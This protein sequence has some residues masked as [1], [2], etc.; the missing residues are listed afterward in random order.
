MIKAFPKIFAIGT[1]YIKDI[2]KDEVEITEKVDGSQFCFADHSGTLYM[3][4][5]GKQQFAEAYDKMFKEAVSYALELY[6]NNTLPRD[7]VFYCEYLKTPKHN[8]LSY[9]LIPKN[10][11]M[12]FAIS[13]I[14]GSKFFDYSTIVQWANEL[15][16]DYAKKFP[17]TQ[18]NTINDLIDLLEHESYLG[19][20][21]IEGIV[22]KNY[23]R[24]FLLGG[25][26][27]PLMAGKFVSESFKEVNRSNFKKEHLTTGRWQLF[28]DSYRTEAR[29]HKAIQHL[30]EQDKISFEPK[31]IGLLIKEIQSDIIEE[32]KETIKEF[33]WKEFGSDLIRRSTAGFAEFYKEYLANRSFDGGE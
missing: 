9:E 11:L 2:F 14:Y 7:L 32:E 24:P 19:K 12:L 8:C 27:I 10:H 23:N 18:I 22:V 25:Q 6:R 1:D 3:R 28:I 4:S 29:W 15:D 21:K 30:A 20:T 5:K 31:D 16:I 33:L 26:P 17:I 13:D